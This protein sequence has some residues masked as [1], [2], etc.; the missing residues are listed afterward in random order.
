MRPFPENGDFFRGGAP[1]PRDT[2]L[3]E[4]DRPSRLEAGLEV[5]NG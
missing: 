4:K 2:V 1:A 3:L 5:R